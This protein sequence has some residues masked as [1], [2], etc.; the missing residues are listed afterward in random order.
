MSSTY[1]YQL[2]FDVKTEMGAQWAEGLK[3]V[4][5]AHK[6]AG[7][8]EPEIYTTYIGNGERAFVRVPLDKIGD[9]DDWVHTP[10]LVHK[11]LGEQAGSDALAKWAA[12]FTHWESRLLR[13]SK[14]GH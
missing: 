6:Q 12:T 10:D 13:L 7:Q 14:D 11:M 4:L 5:D 3:I 2:E 1:V 8:A 9:M